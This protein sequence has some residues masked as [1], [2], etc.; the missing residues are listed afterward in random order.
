[1][2]AILLHKIYK[3][4]KKSRLN[5]EQLTLILIKSR[6]NKKKINNLKVTTPAPGERGDS[7]YLN[8]SRS[9][10]YKKEYLIL[11]NTVK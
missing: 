8:K 2:P 5:L 10:G 9:A 4:V 11:I 6:V 3:G 1:M 7:K